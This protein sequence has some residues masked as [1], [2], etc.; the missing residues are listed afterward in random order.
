[1]A[2]VPPSLPKFHAFKSGSFYYLRTY[3]N[4]WDK[5]KGYPVKSNIKSIAKILGSNGPLGAIEWYDDFLCQF[6]K[7]KDFDASYVLNEITGKKEVRFVEK[8][9]S[10][11]PTVNNVVGH[12]S[13]GA[14]LVLNSLIHSDPIKKSLE[15]VFPT[16]WDKLLSLAYFM[17]L[18]GDLKSTHYASFAKHTALPCQDELNPCNISRIFH[19]ID[20]N[21]VK[22]F[23]STYL[24]MLEE[25]CLFN[26]ERFFAFDSTNSGTYGTFKNARFGHSKHDSDL[27]QLNCV[28]ICDERTCRP[29]YYDI[30]NGAVPDVSAT[31]NHLQN[32]LHL[33]TKSFVAVMD[34]GYYS[35]DNL[36]ELF[37]L[38][39]HFLICL[40]VRK[41][42]I[43]DEV[44]DEAVRL[45]STGDYY[46]DKYEQ[47]MYHQ[48]LEFV[49]KKDGKNIKRKLHIHVFEDVEE[50]SAQ[51]KNLQR[52]RERVKSYLKQNLELDEADKQFAQQYLII[53]ENNKNKIENNHEAYQEFCNRAG[54]FV[55][56]SDIIH[57]SNTA[58]RAYL[59]RQVV[60]DCF[61][62]LKTRMNTKRYRVGSEE[63]LIGKAFVEFIA[64][65]IYMLLDKR[66]DK[67]RAEG[68]KILY[69]SLPAL[70]LELEGITKYVYEDGYEVINSPSLQQS[71]GLK[72]FGIKLPSGGYKNAKVAEANK[73]K[74]AGKPH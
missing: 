26:K 45:F 34:R 33:G 32:L 65:S 46:N 17:V 60:E 9:A 58:Y 54:L 41:L 22:S 28:M 16:L 3:T 50:S 1:M 30:Y 6:P 56:A 20:E 51:I 44:I 37:T 12:F 14:S 70:L 36:N 11:P 72:L 68:I 74:S 57:D 7:L 66:L 27:P 4:T 61:S 71:H 38:G 62:S 49:F 31:I 21:L 40:P 42:K 67:K 59:N 23:L 48:V 47:N 52:R 8:S 39:Y 43:C 69:N 2:L 24:P 15:I 53:D 35:K 73:V 63:S 10:L 19:S 18:R 25:T 55:L 5:E 29:L 13:I 64:I